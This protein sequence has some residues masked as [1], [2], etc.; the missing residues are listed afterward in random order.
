MISLIAP[1]LL[2]TK[3]R[4]A[5][6]DPVAWPVVLWMCRF[7]TVLKRYKNGLTDRDVVKVEDT[8]GPKEPLLGLYVS[9]R[10]LHIWRCF[11]F[12]VCIT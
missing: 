9:C 5:V 8:G 6:T 4:P 7:V 12:G 3:M 11:E 10:H 1:G 2:R